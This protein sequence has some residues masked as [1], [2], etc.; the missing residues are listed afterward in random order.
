MAACEACPLGSYA[1]QTTG[2]RDYRKCPL[3]GGPSCLQPNDDAFTIASGAVTCTL[4][5]P[6]RPFTWSG[7]ST[8]AEDCRRCQQGYFFQGN[9]C[10]QCSGACNVP[11]EY[12]AVPCTDQTDRQCQPCNYYSCSLVGEYVDY[13][14]GCPGA[15]DAHRPCAAC[16]NKPLNSM[17]VFPSEMAIISGEDCTWQCSGGFYLAPGTQEC[18]ACTPVEQLREVCVPGFIMT[19]CS[20]AM[21]LDTSCSQ[22]CDAQALG[23]PSDDTSEWVWTTYAEQQDGVNILYNPSGGSDGRPN[24]GCM[25]KCRAGFSMKAMDVGLLGNDSMKIYLCV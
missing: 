4:C 8:G 17:Y 24:V 14:R 1:K 5:P 11:E 10:Q 16:T 3:G 20:P 12:E 18:K 19:P 6:D 23:K 2:L 21:G 25:W 13:G 9:S 7:G 15:I 22:R